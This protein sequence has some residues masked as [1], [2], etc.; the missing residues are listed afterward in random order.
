MK[1]TKRR[2]FVMTEREASELSM[3]A[4][5]ACMSE[6]QLI[7][8]LIS[9][10]HPPEAPGEEFHKDMGDLITVA[11]KMSTLAETERDPEIRKL[12]SDTSMDLK[13]LSLEI[14]RRYL[15]GERERLRWQ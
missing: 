15:T 3:K 6:S 10:Y 8:L 5:K 14:R 2:E 4:Q 11:E 13:K 7:R 12:L 1:R 9:G